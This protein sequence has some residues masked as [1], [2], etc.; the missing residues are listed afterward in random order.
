MVEK[1]Q[2]PWSSA[3]EVENRG[4]R[5]KPMTL[6]LSKKTS[7]VCRTSELCEKYNQPAAIVG[8]FELLR[9]S[10]ANG[11]C[12]GRP[13]VDSCVVPRRRKLL[14]SFV[15]DRKATQR[16]NADAPTASNGPWFQSKNSPKVWSTFAVRTL[17]WRCGTFESEVGNINQRAHVQFEQG[18][19]H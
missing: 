4:W 8:H 6:F 1:R 16:L 17:S 13:V 5:Y 2:A 14:R 3:G 10:A 19:S 12:H 15:G 11:V 7:N 18:N 9:A